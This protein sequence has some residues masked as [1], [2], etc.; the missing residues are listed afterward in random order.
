MSQLNYRL[1]DLEVWAD[2]ALLS[3]LIWRVSNPFTASSQQPARMSRA[4][5]QNIAQAL[6][7]GI[8]PTPQNTPLQATPGGM[9]WVSLCFEAAPSMPWPAFGVES[10]HSQAMQRSLDLWVYE[11]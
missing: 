4:Q 6:G 1:Y 7:D 5:A 10:G 3:L 11:C 9:R 8:A 2:F